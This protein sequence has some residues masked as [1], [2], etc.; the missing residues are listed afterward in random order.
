M[1]HGEEAQETNLLTKQDG[2]SDGVSLLILNALVTEDEV[3]AA[4]E[5]KR[6]R[7]QSRIQPFP[8]QTKDKGRRENRAGRDSSG[9]FIH[10][11]IFTESLLRVM[12]Q[13]LFLSSEYNDFHKYF[14]TN[15][16]IMEAAEG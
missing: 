14:L 8:S 16:K 13:T 2:C 7:E 9:R 12:C 11:N 4:E 10:S 3:K 6:K 1:L 15:R 5:N